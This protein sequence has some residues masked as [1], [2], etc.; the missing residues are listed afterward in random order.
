MADI[1]AAVEASVPPE[2]PSAWRWWDVFWIS[3]VGVILV[4]GSSVAAAWFASQKF[5]D[6]VS[7]ESQPLWFNA[8]LAALE[9][10]GLF[11]AVYF[12]G[13]RRRSF[14]WSQVGLGAIHPAWL[15]GAFAAAMLLIPAVGVIVIVIQMLLGQPLV[16]PQL[17]F[18]APQD[19]SWVGAA[20]ML[21][22]AGLAVPFAEELFFRGV[23]YSWLSR[24]FGVIIAALVSSLLFGLLHGELAI[25][26]ATF[27]MGL[28]LAWF[29]QRSRS[30]WPS[31]FIHV[32]NN[33][34]KL[35]LLYVFIALGIDISGL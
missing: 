4:L 18:L 22:F 9:A 32:I 5:P 13:M 30:L 26:G 25:A 20:G 10:L 34:F 21:L 7:L 2:T 1:P 14:S 11:I 29:Y 19:F 24:R 28:A 6:L 17:E 8:L 16:N 33:S 23:L 35:F 31:I 12:V 3:L 27:L 15:L